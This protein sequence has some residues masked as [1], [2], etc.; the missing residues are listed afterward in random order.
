ME[1]AAMVNVSV[2]PPDTIYQHHTSTPFTTNEE[3]SIP[4]KPEMK[5]LHEPERY[6]SAKAKPIPAGSEIKS[7]RSAFQP[8][9][10]LS[11]IP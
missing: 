5:E 8:K 7:S 9:P 10:G 4:T 3:P 1:H 6:F 11:S 2:Q